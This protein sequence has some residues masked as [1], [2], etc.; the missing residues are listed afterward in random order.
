MSDVVLP[1]F[2]LR[3]SAFRR[4]SLVSRPFA[5]ALP[6]TAPPTVPGIPVQAA[7]LSRPFAEVSLMSFARIAPASAL[8]VF[9]DF[10]MSIL[11]AVSLMMRPRNPLSW[12]SM[13]EP[14]PTM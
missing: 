10:W 6:L 5:P 1:V 13:F 7:R 8:T 12:K 11:L 3:I 14:P 2:V 9:L 4:T